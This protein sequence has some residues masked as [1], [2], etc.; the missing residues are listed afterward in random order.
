[1]DVITTHINADFDCLGA[2][3]AARRLYPD[4]AMVFAGSQE[5]SLREFLLRSPT[6]TLEFE[7]I[8]DIDLDR[9]DR[10]ILVDVRQS[11]RIGPFGEVARRPG[12]AV[13]IYDH[14]PE[15]LADLHGVV[16]QVE[17]V[18]ASVTV[19]AHI[20]M[21]RGIVPEPNEATM[22]MLGLYE[23]TGCLL[24][25]STTVRD[26]EAAAFLHAHGADLAT[27][28]EFLS[29]E[30]TVDQVA[31]LHELIKSRTVLNLGGI[32]ISI[33]HASIDH[34]VGDLAVLAHKLK[35]ME[36]LNAL[37]VAVRM[38]DRVFMVGRSRIPQVNVGE[39]L[40]EFGGGGHAFAASGTLREQTLIQILDRLPEVLRRHVRPQREARQLMSAPV[41]SITKSTTV[42]EVREI[43]TRYNINAVPV[44]ARRRVVGIITRQVADKA[45]HHGLAELP[46][47]E[48]MSS[49]FTAVSPETP[50]ASVQEL[51]VERNQRFVPVVEK[52]RLVGAVTR[53]DLLRHLVDGARVAQSAL[54]GD[55]AGAPTLKKRQVARLLREQLPSPILALLQALGKVGEDL[56]VGVFIVGGFVRDLLLRQRNLD[57]DLVVEGDGIAFASEYA[58]RYGCRIRTHRKFGTAVIIHPDGF[59]VDVASTRMEY[60]LEPGALPKVE[61]ASIKLDLYRRDFTI[62]TLA[63]ALNQHEFGE[64]LDF[65]GAQRDLQDKAIRVLHNL[66]FVEDPTRVFRAIRFE[67][68]LAFR[69]GKHTEYLLRSAMRMGFL[70]K[71]GGLRLFN[72]LVIILK[73]ADPLPAVFRMAELDLLKYV[74]P[75]LLLTGRSRQLFESAGRTLHWYELLYTGESCHRWL[76]YFLCLAAPLDQDAMVGVCR[77]LDVPPRY[78]D[79]FCAEREDAHRLLQLLERRRAKASDPRSSDLYHWLKPFSVEVLLYLMARAGS[80]EVR[81]WFSHFFTH[82]RS[83]SA[84]L[85]GRDLQLLG[86]PPGP[87]FKKIL[88]TLLDARLNGRVATRE[89][90][91]ALVRRR[92]LREALKGPAGKR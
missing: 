87:A 23:D 74:H 51:I 78:R 20:L 53:T 43:L 21:A 14:H 15:G 9:I 52:G 62:N 70:D 37:L 55:A 57:L 42:A 75:S 34:F 80:E 64:L 86:I 76:V 39:I 1:M 7:R 28:G 54:A 61:H 90:E 48:C 81:R 83:V 24:F 59:K 65:F 66:S 89:D 41:K 72:E 88:A 25:N 44:L 69:I 38:G 92:F 47:S 22:M 26:F 31:L 10:L 13:H 82:L 32:D 12:V 46:V 71:V 58:R 6:A 29:Q 63:V 18:G 85:T 19:L 79:I 8:R 17:P 2:M 67:Q 33:A 3:V 27:V 91:L 50:I 35:D 84:H 16:E 49:E 11:D 45:A 77:R 5:R 4:A 73:E 36:N 56:E 68:R 30:L 40:G 60:Y